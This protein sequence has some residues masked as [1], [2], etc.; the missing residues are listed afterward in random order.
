MWNL[1]ALTIADLMPSQMLLFQIASSREASSKIPS[2]FDSFCHN[3]KYVFASMSTVFFVFEKVSEVI[4]DWNMET[5]S[6]GP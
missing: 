2:R 6:E 5:F 1:I 3:T 4:H